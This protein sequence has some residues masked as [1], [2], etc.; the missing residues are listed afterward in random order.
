[1]DI[2]HC[3]GIAAD[4]ARSEGAACDFR[5]VL[6]LAAM[7]AV[8][9]TLSHLLAGKR[10]IPILGADRLSYMLIP[11]TV[12]GLFYLLAF[13]LH[14]FRASRAGTTPAPWR[15]SAEWRPLPGAAIVL[16]AF[17]G[18]TS[19]GDLA[20]IYRTHASHWHDAL[21]WHLEYPLHAALAGS[22]LDWPRFWDGIYFQMWTFVLVVAAHAYSTEGSRRCA[23]LG[24]SI[25]LAFYLTRAINLAFPTAGPAF[26]QPTAF[27]LDGTVSKAVQD[28]LRAYMAGRLPANGIYPATM[29][30]PSLHVGLTAI[31]VWFLAERRPWSL[32]FS[33]PWLL[34]M[35]LST[36]VL[37]WH[38][39]LDG[40]A[41]LLVAA[42]A[43]G[44]A[45]RVQDAAERYVGRRRPPPV[46]GAAEEGISPWKIPGTAD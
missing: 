13:L 32:C 8:L 14:L 18:I 25:L 37:G 46:A 43:V 33:L 31:A 22:W 20:E 28:L 40:L 1:M 21:L 5:D 30:L 34:M 26:F 36:V 4:R 12:W 42:V 24:L 9:G 29:A 45:G 6:P 19:S 35:W 27:A 38:Y 11:L 23:V 2:G 15:G 17:Y 41:G 39:F 16:L 3:T 7:V 10:A 44:L